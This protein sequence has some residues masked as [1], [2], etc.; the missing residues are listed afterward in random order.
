[1]IK[2]EPLFSFFLFGLLFY[3]EIVFFILS[4][5]IFS[6]TSSSFSFPLDVLRVHN[7]EAREQQKIV[8]QRIERRKEV[9]GVDEVVVNL[10]NFPLAY[11]HYGIR[12]KS[13]QK[14]LAKDAKIFRLLVERKIAKVHKMRQ[15]FLCRSLSL[16]RVII[17]I[18]L[19]I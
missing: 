11:W 19:A 12:G 17:I 15:M 2:K 4:H 7:N 6:T 5:R 1:M 9:A 10:G 16:F 14:V 13:I 3:P 18:L 8:F